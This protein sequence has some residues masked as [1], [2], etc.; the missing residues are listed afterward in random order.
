[1]IEGYPL[2]TIKDLF[3]LNNGSVFSKLELQHAYQQLEVD[4]SSQEMLT[5]N[6]CKG[7]YRYQHLPFGISSA[8]L[9]FQA[10]MDQI[11]K[12][13]KSTV[14]Y[15]DDILVTR[16]DEEDHRKALEGVLKCLEDHGIKLKLAK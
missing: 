9:I 2:P 6:T 11:L 10:V 13:Q 14:C 1:M 15:S 8:P 4:E 16:K 7:L 3:S 5:I 12:G